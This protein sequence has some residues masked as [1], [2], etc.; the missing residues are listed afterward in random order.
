MTKDEERLM[1]LFFQVTRACYDGD[2]SA[3]GE[4]KDQILAHYR[5][6]RAIVD[7]PAPVVPV[8]LDDEGSKWI[9]DPDG[10]HGWWSEEP[11]AYDDYGRTFGPWDRGDTTLAHGRLADDGTQ[12]RYY[13]RVS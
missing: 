6:T 10:T 11:G 2:R 1:D 5:R 3:L 13:R 12:L 9:E 8:Y 4:L 7:G